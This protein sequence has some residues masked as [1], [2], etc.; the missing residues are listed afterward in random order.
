VFDFNSIMDLLKV[1]PGHGLIQSVI[2]LGIWLQARGVKQEISKLASS[3]DKVRL[4]TDEK[5]QQH[6][7]RLTKLEIVGE[8]K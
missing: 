6:D 2:L 3:L 4:D 5:L 1:E 7:I 8:T